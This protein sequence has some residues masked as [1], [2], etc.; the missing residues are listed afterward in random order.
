MFL[1]AGSGWWSSQK[2]QILTIRNPAQ[3]GPDS[4]L[5]GM[6]LAQIS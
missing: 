5:V 3:A 4:I 1:R 2:R 6:Q